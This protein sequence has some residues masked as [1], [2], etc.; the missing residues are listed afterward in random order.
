MIEWMVSSSVL[1]IV[2]MTI[3]YFFRNRLSMRARYALWLL[4]AVRLLMP[5]SFPGSS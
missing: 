5:F 4:V 2:I 1:M 3:R